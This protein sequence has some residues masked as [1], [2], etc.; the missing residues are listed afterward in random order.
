MGFKE[1]YLDYAD[2]LKIRYRL[3]DHAKGPS[4]LLI[5]GA[6]R[7]LED[8]D[9]LFPYFD[10]AGIDLHAVELRGHGLSGG[11]KYHIDGFDLY[12]RDLKRFIFGNLQNKPVY[13]VCEGIGF[14]VALSIASDKR[15][16]VKGLVAVSP[17]FELKI[18]T[19]KRIS[20]EIIARIL[21][22][23]KIYGIPLTEI[24]PATET[25]EKTCGENPE[26]PGNNK[27]AKQPVYTAGFYAALFSAMKKARKE[28][29][30]T[31][32][33]LLV[34]GENDSVADS[35]LTEGIF[36][37]AYHQT[38]NLK[39]SSCKKCGHDLLLESERLD[40]I[41]KITRWIQRQESS[42]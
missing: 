11:K 9:Y 41:E 2:G 17:F 5:H 6:E 29:M 38:Q 4:A 33:C 25:A 31:V 28:I 10:T 37:R 1:G 40:N 24:A 16:A 30:Q 3:N 19:S 8:F 15:F 20:I 42:C 32:P 21:P 39:I 14:F 13:L 12:A 35:L 34:T 36:R 22:G 18:P 23:M 7:K 26:I 27:P